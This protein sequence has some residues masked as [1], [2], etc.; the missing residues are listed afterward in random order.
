MWTV[1]ILINIITRKRLKY[2]YLSFGS[3]IFPSN[4]FN[5]YSIYLCGYSGL[6]LHIHSGIQKLNQIHWILK[7]FF[8]SL[9]LVDRLIV[10][11]FNVWHKGKIFR[12]FAWIEKRIDSKWWFFYYRKKW[13]ISPIYFHND[14]S[15]FFPVII[16][17]IP[18]VCLT[19]NK[20]AKR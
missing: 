7:S 2:P 16:I 3:M 4:D 15:C 13:R 19:K 14:Q 1:F 18:C 20:N 6:L 17:Q 10:S 11:F 12:F 5:V 8:F 9:S